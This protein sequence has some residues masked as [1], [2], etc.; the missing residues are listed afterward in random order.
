MGDEYTD[1]QGGGIYFK[2]TG[3]GNTG[4]VRAAIF[5]DQPVYPL[6]APRSVSAQFTFAGT[7]G[8]GLASPSAGTLQLLTGGS[9][10]LALDVGQN[11]SIGA[12]LTVAGSTS[13]AALYA[14][15]LALTGTLGVSGQTTLQALT[16]TTTQVSAL[17]ATTGT[18]SGQLTADSLQVAHAATVGG[19]L[20]ASGALQA[21]SIT[22]TGALAGATLNVSGAAQLG[23]TL[24][25]L[26][27][28]QLVDAHATG[29]AVIDGNL[30]VTGIATL[31][32]NSIGNGTFGAI[33]LKAGDASWTSSAGAP[34][35]GDGVFG[36]IRSATDSST[37][38]PFYVKAS[39]G[40]V[41]LPM[42][43]GGGSVT[44][45]LLAPKNA[46]FIPY[47]FNGLPNTGLKG[48]DASVALYVDDGSSNYAYSFK[49]TG[50]LN[51]RSLA[52][53]DTIT[54]DGVTST[55]NGEFIRL[56]V[57][58]SK[59][60]A[61]GIDPNGNVTGNLGDL[62]LRQDVAELYIKDTGT[63]FQG[64]KKVYPPA[65]SGA[66]FPLDAPLATAAQFRF[67][68]TDTAR[69]T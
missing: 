19:A 12:G 68:G 41:G 27:A 8:D 53:G 60:Y 37:P 16:A 6:T 66:V 17:T 54:C 25:I 65:A 55:G 26:G 52:V 46:A 36:D 29:N 14:S 13:L 42:A 33:R 23:S 18:F 51:C 32:N 22:S 20:T 38:Y 62:V 11:V 35:A 45:P 50:A 31:G 47:G 63:P 57:N 39:S 10:G 7:G 69:L 28:T 21:P 5:G 30:S 34:A 3:S 48:F 44:F 56:V 64:W 40:W 49:S 58:G 61:A 1:T 15:N 43:S 67:N 2:A 9:V 4:W 24:N 59:I